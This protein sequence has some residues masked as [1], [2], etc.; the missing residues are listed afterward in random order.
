MLKLF[1]LLT[2]VALPA[3]AETTYFYGNDGQNI[4]SAMSAGNSTFYYDAQGNNVG[5]AL[6]AGNTT[7]FYGN[8]GESFSA[9][10]VG[11]RQR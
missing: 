11:G 8:N 10:T 5:T 9:Q 4:G 7:Y 6:P 3:Q 2:L 1:T